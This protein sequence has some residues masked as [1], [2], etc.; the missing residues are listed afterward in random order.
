MRHHEMRCYLPKYAPQPFS[1]AVR[2]PG[3]YPEGTVSI[4][5]AGGEE[6]HPIYTWC[7]QVEGPPMTFKLSAATSVEFTGVERGSHKPSM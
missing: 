6:T 7:R 5:S 3:M 1:F 2:R 4:E